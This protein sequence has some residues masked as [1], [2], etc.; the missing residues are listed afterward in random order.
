LQYKNRILLKPGL[1]YWFFQGL[2]RE[3]TSRRKKKAAQGKEG[4][5]PCA[6]LENPHRSLSILWDVILRGMWTLLLDYSLF[7][8]PF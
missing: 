4:S 6:A 8:R 2:E 7:G 1:L 3:S 5:K